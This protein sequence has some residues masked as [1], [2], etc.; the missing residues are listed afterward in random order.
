MG[1]PGPHD[2]NG[3]DMWEPGAVDG[4]SI[5]DKQYVKMGCQVTRL[6]SI[7]GCARQLHILCLL[8]ATSALRQDLLGCEF[9]LVRRTEHACM[10]D[11]FIGL[12]CVE[13]RGSTGTA[14][15]CGWKRR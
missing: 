3:S 8:L 5:M 14:N 6:V 13:R 10:Y 1:L 4:V 2:P 12:D 15:H 7:K 11:V 9:V